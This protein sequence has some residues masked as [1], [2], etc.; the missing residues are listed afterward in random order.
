MKNLQQIEQF[1]KGFSDLCSRLDAFWIVRSRKLRTLEVIRLLLLQVESS[2]RSSL[3][4]V[5]QLAQI[6]GSYS[7]RVSASALSQ[8][9]GRMHWSY[10][11]ELFRY[12]VTFHQSHVPQPLWKGRRIFAIDGTRLAIPS[13]FNEKRYIRTAKNAHYPQAMLTVLYQL[14]AGIP[15]DAQFCRHFDERRAALHHLKCLRAGDVVVVDRGFFLQ[16]FCKLA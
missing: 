11:R 7:C 3:L 10:V 16:N 12:A 1:S 8:A 2:R 4:A 9:R 14:K 5:A 6:L 13:H 15:H